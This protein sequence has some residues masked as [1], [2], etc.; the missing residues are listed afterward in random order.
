MNKDPKACVWVV[1]LAFQQRLLCVHICSVQASESVCVQRKGRQGKKRLLNS[2]ESVREFGAGGGMV[3]VF[4][5]KLA[6]VGVTGGTRRGAANLHS[7]LLLS[8]LSLAY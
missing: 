6:G 8:L 3:A 2:L 7:H 1:G 5:L 4:L